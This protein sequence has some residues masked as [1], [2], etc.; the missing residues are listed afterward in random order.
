MLELGKPIHTFDGAAVHAGPDGRATIIVRRAVAGERLETLDH[1]ERE[2]TADTLLIADPS[3]PLGVAGVMGGAT[4]E[5]SDGTTEVIVE[6]AIFDPVSIRR[7]AQRLGLRSEASS[8]FEKGQEFRLARLGADRAAQLVQA[9]SGGEVL[10]RRRRH[11]PRGAGSPAASP[12][13]RPASTGCWGPSSRRTSSG[14]SWRGWAWSPSPPRQAS[15][16]RSRSNPSPCSWSRTREPPLRPWFP[17][18]AATSPSRRTSSRRSPASAATSWCPRSP[19][20]P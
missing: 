12:S 19:P 10:R 9:W 15:W 8:R 4:S 2:L 16:W 5:V 13:G 14:R 7:T 11:G 17:P 6:S 20:T 1:V 18:G 3:G